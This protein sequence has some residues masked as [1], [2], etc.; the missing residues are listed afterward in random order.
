MINKPSWNRK[1]AS[2]LVRALSALP[3]FVIVV[4]VSLFS[5]DSRTVFE[6]PWL[7]S[8]LNAVFL[9]LIPAVIV[10]ITMKA[11]LSSG[12]MGILGLSC[13]AFCMGVSASAVGFLIG[14]I[15]GPNQAVTVYNM[16][17]FLAG[18]FHCAGAGVALT[19]VEP[20]SNPKRRKTAITVL[21][22]GT[23][24]FMGM[25]IMAA[26]KGHTPVF[27]VQGTGTTLIRQVV[28]GGAV[29]L[30]VCAAGLMGL[31]YLRSRNHFQYWYCLGLLLIGIGLFCVLLPR[32]VGGPIGWL[33]RLAQYLGAV[34]FLVAVVSAFREIRAKGMLLGEGISH[35]FQH[36]LEKLVD[37]RT[38]EWM[39]VNERL[40]QE[41]SVR[42]SAEEA[43]QKAQDLLEQRVA[44]RT[45]ALA[46][47][48]S[49]HRETE[50]ALGES[51][52][53]Y[54]GIFDNTQNGI[55]VYEAVNHGEDF[56][57][58]E[59]NSAAARIEQAEPAQMVGRSMTE[60][61]P[62]FKEL[63]LLKVLQR[64]WR[65]GT[66]EFFC[67]TSQTEEGRIALWRENFV[68]KLPTGEIVVVYQDETKRKQAEADREKLQAQLHQA[69]RMESIGVLAGGVAHDFNNLLTAVMGN[70]QLVLAE[71]SKNDPLREDVEEIRKAGDRGAMLT[72]Q[73]MTFSRREPSNMEVLDL[74][75][76]VQDMKKLLRRLVRESIELRTISAAELWKIQADVGQMEQVIMN[77]VVNARDVMP[78]GGTLTIETANV[79]LNRAYFD[80]HGIS[81]KPGAYVMLAVT[82]TGPGM[83]EKI[84]E[85]I[86]DPFFTT[87]E[88]GAGTGLG[89]S[90]VYGI[91][92]QCKGYIWPYSAPGEGTTMKAYFPRV[93][94]MQTP[95][96]KEAPIREES[97]GGESVLVVE[98]DA[99]LRTL[100][101][102]SLQ[103][104][105]YE[106][107]S[108][109]DGEDAIRVIER[110][111]G[112]I[113]LLL[114]D[115]VMPKMGGRELAEWMR[116]LHPEVK[117]L[118]M[119]GFP[120]RG[121]LDPTL[122]PG[123]AFIEKPFSPE[124]LCRKA[125]EAIEN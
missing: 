79:E 43:L 67:M 19:G 9:S 89:L 90:V 71:L 112:K 95:K 113:R 81:G 76:V 103:K 87:K 98:D 59:I 10:F 25:W 94:A 66:A 41:I 52:A 39:V 65:T 122:E 21:Y 80:S 14:G 29:G 15:D 91:I 101:V 115:V 26:I 63:G 44:K 1:T 62:A 40:T 45:A 88:R 22:F 111:E 124:A 114:T 118:Y 97:G 17:F 108:A 33:G 32:T 13:G 57:L 16:G 125:R 110:F 99:P 30:F 85:R 46:R 7:L 34:Y 60:A 121:F 36:R 86:F 69:Q 106:V 35:L 120:D 47:E 27:F 72:R 6:P 78:N 38:R 119:S 75:E 50:R 107:L 83:D 123:A 49:E 56:I 102:K 74:N 4:L 68:Y 104:A 82:D 23:I 64:V 8:T 28:L 53:R 92:K 61:F 51:H 96:R 18:A 2:R 105:G 58:I 100:V 20:E 109:K 77:L 48:I 37:D 12:S 54:K 31:L 55:A 93:E 73:L 3:I 24:L 70:A 5:S 42:K 117:V 116:T 84:R 11:Y